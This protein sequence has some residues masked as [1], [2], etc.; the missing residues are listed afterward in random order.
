MNRN[1]ENESVLKYK[2]SSPSTSILYVHPRLIFLFLTFFL[3]A[4]FHPFSFRPYMIS[5]MLLGDEQLSSPFFVFSYLLLQTSF[6][7]FHL[8]FRIF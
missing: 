8:F 3:S 7:P 5:S 1:A 2:S 4:F 6:R